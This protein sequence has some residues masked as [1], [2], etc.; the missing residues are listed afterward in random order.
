MTPFFPPQLFPFGVIFIS[1]KKIFLILKNHLLSFHN[2]HPSNSSDLT[3]QK[4]SSHS[5][6]DHHGCRW[7]PKEVVHHTVAQPLHWPSTTTNHHWP[8]SAH[9]S[10]DA[11]QGSGLLEIEHW[12][13]QLMLPP[14]DDT[15]ITQSLLATESHR[16]TPIFKKAEKYKPLF[17]QRRKETRCQESRNI[18]RKHWKKKDWRGN[19]I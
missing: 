13:S 16:A 15:F 4:L 19:M 1:E 12:C 10:T 5:C 8:P 3:Q 11:T 6:Q 2:K 14:R 9:S 17:E 18:Y 7:L